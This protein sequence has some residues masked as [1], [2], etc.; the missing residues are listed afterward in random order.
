MVTTLRMLFFFSTI[1]TTSILISMGF[2]RN[3]I[4]DSL[5][6]EKYLEK[7]DQNLI[8][9]LSFALCLV[10]ILTT[11]FVADYYGAQKAVSI[12]ALIMRIIGLSI[13]ILVLWKLF[14][15]N[16][17]P[18]NFK[19]FLDFNKDGAVALIIFVTI[20]SK[21]ST[22]ILLMFLFVY[23]LRL[24]QS[25]YTKFSFILGTGCLFNSIILFPL[26]LTAYKITESMDGHIYTLKIY[27]LIKLV[28]TVIALCI[29]TF[30]SEVDSFPS[31]E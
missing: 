18:N 7:F 23:L 12:F 14:E 2:D 19:Q 30:M 26:V 25:R 5:R 27:T 3:T 24:I 6:T 13:E 15:F 17:E 22:V 8:K 9:Y 31:S 11:S 4:F 1:F 20:I 29:L 21:F 28:T 10:M 16:N